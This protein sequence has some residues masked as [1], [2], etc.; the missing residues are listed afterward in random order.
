MPCPGAVSMLILPLQV[1]AKG[2]AIRKPSPVPL[3][4]GLVVTNTFVACWATPGAMPV[5]VS[6]TA[7]CCR[8]LV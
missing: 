8:E 6:D 3:P 2:C 1:D 5:P 7:I 4:C